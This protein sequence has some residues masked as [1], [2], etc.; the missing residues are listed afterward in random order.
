MNNEEGQFPDG[1]SLLLALMNSVDR[2]LPNQ[3][4][5]TRLIDRSICVSRCYQ[6]MING[7][8]RNSATLPPPP[9]TPEVIH[10]MTTRLQCRSFLSNEEMENLDEEVDIHPAWLRQK[11]PDPFS[12][13]SAHRR[14]PRTQLVSA[15]PVNEI[16]RIILFSSAVE[17]TS[18]L[19]LR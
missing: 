1:I 5:T 4:T 14:N 19:L 11:L 13:S 10:D 16:R 12:I 8:R 18:C 6:V 7:R 9:W 3:L 2:S 15:C 17:S